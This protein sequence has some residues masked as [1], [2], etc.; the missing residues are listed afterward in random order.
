MLMEDNFYKN[1]NKWLINYL[2]GDKKYY[3]DIL[4]YGE[5]PM[6]REKL[7]EVEEL[8]DRLQGKDVE[9]AEKCDELI[10]EIMTSLIENKELELKA[11]EISQIASNWWIEKI[12]NPSNNLGYGD[13]LQ[14]TV[15]SLLSKMRNLDDPKQIEKLDC[16][17]EELKE[18]IKERLIQEG[19]VYLH[20]DYEA[21]DILV[22]AALMA[23][24]NLNSS[25]YLFPMKS[26]MFISFDRIRAAEGYGNEEEVL[27]EK[28]NSKA[29][30]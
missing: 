4:S 10:D 8:I 22:Q 6:Y 14:T 23:G 27:Y 26:H 2:E 7:N 3:E 21:D 11:E 24:F 16:L 12:K 29:I 28:N 17:N 5:I 20:V 19:S 9:N 1:P 18:A 30:K 15:S 25:Q 13:E